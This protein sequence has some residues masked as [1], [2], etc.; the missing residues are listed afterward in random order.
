MYVS[1]HHAITEAVFSICE[2]VVDALKASSSATDIAE[3]QQSLNTFTYQLIIW[4]PNNVTPRHHARG[5]QARQGSDR[6]RLWFLPTSCTSTPGLQDQLSCMD[7]QNAS[8]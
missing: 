8:L 1:M 6:S 2:F 3:F 4:F 7:I 5:F